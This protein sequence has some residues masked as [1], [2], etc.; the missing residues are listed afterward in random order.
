MLTFWVTD[1]V[2]RDSVD[3]GAAMTSDSKESIDIGT[4]EGEKKHRRSRFV[5]PN[6]SRMGIRCCRRKNVDRRLAVVSQPPRQNHEE[7]VMLSTA[8]TLFL[9][10]GEVARMDSSCRRLIILPPRVRS[11]RDL[12]GENHREIRDNRN[13]FSMRS[14]GS[15]GYSA[16]C[17]EMAVVSESC[18]PHSSPLSAYT[19]LVGVEFDI[20]ESMG[21]AHCATIPMNPFFCDRTIF[22]DGH[23]EINAPGTVRCIDGERRIKIRFGQWFDC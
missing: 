23:C 10:K 2:D 3:D 6:R 12:L 19:N 21:V 7:I 15:V 8:P 17:A 20:C 16:H 9:I 1:G 4:K 22:F 11:K 14:T 18:Q 13:D 5:Q